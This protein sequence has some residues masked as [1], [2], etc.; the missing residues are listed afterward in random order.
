[1]NTTEIELLVERTLTALPERISGNEANQVV[2]E[3]L[4]SLAVTDRESLVCYLR[5]LMSYRVF[6]HQRTSSD[7]VPEAG[8]WMALHV[9]KVLGLQELQPDIQKLSGDI[10]RGLIFKPVHQSMVNR[11]LEQLANQ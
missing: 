1:M 7:A 11:Y 6:D 5:H 9:I 4:R 10:E 3:R 2:A 8:I